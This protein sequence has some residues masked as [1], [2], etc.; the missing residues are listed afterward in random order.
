MTP[1]LEELSPNHSVTLG[2]EHTD[3]TGFGSGDAGDHDSAKITL[4][5]SDGEHTF[6]TAATVET[7]PQ[8]DFVTLENV[9]A[10]IGVELLGVVVELRGEV[11]ADGHY[12]WQD[13]R[14]GKGRGRRVRLSQ[15][16]PCAVCEQALNGNAESTSLGLVCRSCARKIE[17]GEAEEVLNR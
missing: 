5:N 16:V 6:T 7:N 8:G 14:E 12:I 2:E 3:E 10:H 17:N 13:R 4:V 9:P 11:V 1:T 15:L